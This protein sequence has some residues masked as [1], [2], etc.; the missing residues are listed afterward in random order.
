MTQ[1]K[2]VE[3]SCKGLTACAGCKHTR[4][5]KADPFGDGKFIYRCEKCHRGLDP[6]EQYSC[7]KKEYFETEVG[8]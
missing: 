5:E 7:H 8:E 3:F 6:T 2:V 4:F 1:L